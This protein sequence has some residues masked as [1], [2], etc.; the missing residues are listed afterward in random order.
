M[1]TTLIIPGIGNS[2]P[3]HWQTLWEK[4]DPSFRRVEQDEWNSPHRADW[5][6]RL[7][8]IIASVPGKV[9][10]VS[11]SSACALVAHWTVQADP[12]RQ[13]KVQGALLVGPS[14][15]EGP[16]YP[17]GPTG[18]APV[19]LVSLPFPSI[20]VASS[21]DPFV[22]VPRAREYAAA[23]GSRFVLIENA[24]HINASSGLGNWPEGF[25]LF[26]ELRGAR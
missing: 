22:T 24:G 20:V 15:P 19:P 1:A 5:V 8:D 25:S 18:F 6:R 21:D 26:E 2:G 23:W 3:D 14:D 13:G 16:C 10:L 17:V 9:I 7:D 11:H 4:R 12:L